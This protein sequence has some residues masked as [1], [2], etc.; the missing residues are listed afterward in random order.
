MGFE[1]VFDNLIFERMTASRKKIQSV[2]DYFLNYC[3]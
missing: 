2:V 3:F 1:H